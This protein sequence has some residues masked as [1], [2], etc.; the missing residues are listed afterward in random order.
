MPHIVS[1]DSVV[2]TTHEWHFYIS[3]HSLSL[4]GLHD[5]CNGKKV[6]RIVKKTS[7]F[8]E[9]IVKLSKNWD[10]AS[11]SV[12]F[13]LTV[14]RPFLSGDKIIVRGI[15]GGPRVCDSRGFHFFVEWQLSNSEWR[16]TKGERQSYYEN[17]ENS[18]TIEKAERN[19][20]Q[21][22]DRTKNR[23]VDLSIHSLV[24]RKHWRRKL[25]TNCRNISTQFESDRS[26]I[27]LMLRR[28][29]KW[30]WNWKWTGCFS[31]RHWFI[32]NNKF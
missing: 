1:L 18:N 12:K 20:I 2:R 5:H 29:Q 7:R 19:A 22:K 14:S 26:L 4:Y 13:I 21:P 3:E 24:R 8:I 31:A 17:Q 9:M 10:K 15:H 30:S 25:S 32:L 28:L 11:R 23:P 6:K 27:Y 16:V